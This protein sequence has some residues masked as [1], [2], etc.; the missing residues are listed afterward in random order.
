MDYQ[1]VRPKTQ[2]E[3]IFEAQLRKNRQ[4]RANVAISWVVLVLILLLMFSGEGKLPFGIHGI[5]LDTQFISENW[6][7]IASGITSTIG[8]STSMRITS[9]CRLGATPTAPWRCAN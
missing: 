8:I 1:D 7:F 5:K 6:S 9:G 4:F 2:A 3:L